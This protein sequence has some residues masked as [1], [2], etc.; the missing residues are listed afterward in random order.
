MARTLRGALGERSVDAAFG[1][2]PLKAQ[3]RMANRAGA[4]FAVIVGER[5]MESGTVTLRRM[6]DGVEVSDVT[7]QGALRVDRR[8]VRAP[9]PRGTGGEA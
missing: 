8:G 1:D 5:E 6:H 7:P 9:P 3:L 2:R 4:T